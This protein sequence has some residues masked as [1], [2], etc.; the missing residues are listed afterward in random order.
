M[1]F[2]LQAARVQRQNTQPHITQT[3]QWP[4]KE[5]RRVMW[6]HTKEDCHGNGRLGRLLLCGFQADSSVQ[7]GKRQ[8]LQDGT[9]RGAHAS[10]RL[11]LLCL[12]AWILL[13]VQTSR[14]LR[15]E[16]VDTF[17]WPVQG[18]RIWPQLYEGRETDLSRLQH[19]WGIRGMSEQMCSLTS[20]R[21]HASGWSVL[22]GLT[23][24]AGSRPSSL[25]PKPVKG[26]GHSSPSW[27]GNFWSSG[28]MLR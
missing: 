13:W 21:R 27:R 25:S 28:T 23:R 12:A 24:R 3:T 19:L 17:L 14:N 7:S 20:L 16:W 22:T 9:D 11:R 2:W 10:S 8:A 5:H 15:I 4:Q 6:R 1:A 26:L 18:Q